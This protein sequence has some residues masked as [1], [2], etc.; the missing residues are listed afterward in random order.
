MEV[1]VPVH[2]Q[3]Y[4]LVDT[5]SAYTLLDIAY[6]PSTLTNTITA[7]KVTLMAANGSAVNVLGTIQLPI[8]LNGKQYT[9]SVLV[10]SQLL[11][12]MI[13]GGDF[14]RHFKSV[15]DYGLSTMT[16]ENN[17]IKLRNFKTPPILLAVTDKS[18]TISECGTVPVHM[19]SHDIPVKTTGYY[20]Y[21]PDIS[22]WAGITNV[23]PNFILHVKEGAFQVAVAVPS[24][25]LQLYLPE[26][27]IL[28]KLI[29]LHQVTAIEGQNNVPLDSADELINTLQIDQNEYL[30]DA[31]RIELKQTF[32]KYA[33][34]FASSSEQVTPTS[35]LT[36]EIH[37]KPDAPEVI[38]V[39]P[40]RLALHLVQQTE[41]E[42]QRLLDNGVIVPSLSPHNSPAVIVKRKD[43]Q[44]RIC[45]DYRN[46]NL[47]TIGY[48]CPLQ[49]V[50]EIVH[51]FGNKE[52]YCTFDVKSAYHT[53][54]LR[55]IDQPL[56]SF[57][58]GNRTFMWTRLATGL[59][60][61]PRY[62][63]KFLQQVFEGHLDEICI[64]FDDLLISDDTFEGI[65]RKIIL[66]M[67]RLKQANV[68][69]SPKKCQIYK[70]KVVYLG[71]LLSKEGFTMTA[72]RIK[73]IQDL[74]FPTTR[75]GLQRVLGVLNFVRRFVPHYSEVIKPITILLR[76]DPDIRKIE[77][78]A[79]SIESFQKLKTLLTNPPLLVIPQKDKTI[80]VMCDGSAIAIGCCIGHRESSTVFNPI[81][82]DSR[83]LS[84]RESKWASF[85]IEFL[86][87][88]YF[89]RK[90]HYLL[91]G[92]KF[93]VE[94]DLALLTAK[95]FLTKGDCTL[96]LRWS[97]YLSTFDFQLSHVPGA[98]NQI[99][100]YLSRLT[101]EDLYSYWAK[102]AKEQSPETLSTAVMT[103][104]N[105]KMN[106]SNR[107]DHS[108]S[109]QGTF[110]Q[111]LPAVCYI[112]ARSL[113]KSQED[114]PDLK[115]VRAWSQENQPTRREAA[116][117]HV[118]LKSLWNKRDS[119]VLNGQG[120][121]CYKKFLKKS[122]KYQLVPLIPK[123]LQGEAIRLVHRSALSPHPGEE[124]TYDV[125]RSS[126]YW[127]KMK[128]DV[129]DFV[130]N[131]EECFIFNLRFKR[132]GR[133][134]MQIFPPAGFPLQT[135]HY[136]IVGPI[137]DNKKHKSYILVF[138][139]RYSKFLY[140]EVLERQTE[141]DVLRVLN[142]FS[143]TY[144][145]PFSLV[146]DNANNLTGSELL[147]TYFAL[148]N[149]KKVTISS[150]RPNVNGLCERYNGVIVKCLRKI[151]A[152]RVQDWKK[153]LPHIIYGLNSMKNETT[154]YTP[155]FLFL[156]R[157][158]RTPYQVVNQ[159]S[160]EEE[161]TPA[162][163]SLSL[164]LKMQEAFQTVQQVAH[165]RMV[166]NKRM[167]DGHGTNVV[168]YELRDIVFVH[169][170]QLRVDDKPYSKFRSYFRGPYLVIAKH[171]EYNLLLADLKSEKVTKAHHDRVRKVTQ[172]LKLTLQIRYSAEIKE[173]LR[174][175]GLSPHPPEVSSADS[176]PKEQPSQIDDSHPTT[177]SR[178]DEDQEDE[179]VYEQQIGL[180]VLHQMIRHNGYESQAG[181][182]VNEDHVV[183]S[184]PRNNRPSGVQT[185]NSNQNQGH[186]AV[187]IGLPGATENRPS[188]TITADTEVIDAQPRSQSPPANLRRSSRRRNKP[189]WHRAYDFRN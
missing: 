80:T 12:I 59:K 58:V 42:V 19:V 112:D 119:I 27:T 36:S 28:G 105:E 150:Y 113:I 135:V 66:I 88:Y 172:Q 148:I 122:Q 53:I 115:I 81:L 14:L 163:R 70:K 128:K 153:M 78:S 83:T 187:Q 39:K 162:Q 77:P 125:I 108:T 127:P 73:I 84:E 56:T 188:V 37:L 20:L 152:N 24:S 171:S 46:L 121:C 160:L 61:A 181:T 91:H 133:Y 136:D 43:N 138:V 117:Y 149:L 184:V 161:L 99:A 21:I 47:H 29:P 74:K 31:Q 111:P 107:E 54:P 69:L 8:T 114:D 140:A 104:T 92:T 120:I 33:E 139:D 75:K 67:D 109:Y 102:V 10:V 34:V 167:Y 157:N 186:E 103:I 144:G 30:T 175:A 141:V 45:A 4:A 174:K 129:Y 15:L 169:F 100:D 96:L 86:A 90:H 72:D 137:S 65:Q 130:R 26:K 183:P 9:W 101:S 57:S 89:V 5:G 16:L 13:I 48:T 50:D 3:V 44:V 158:F 93:R 182:A 110:D 25:E 6:I 132:K 95:N 7:S 52:F 106:A 164:E 142:R 1:V 40:R 18:T 179:E 22:L 170:P 177:S 60:N 94:T 123:S 151:I 63:V 97:I 131:C 11:H 118:S 23:S 51:S 116:P 126:G 159:I 87:I 154:G 176:R 35:L 17:V 62:Y 155:S 156:G 145:L 98:Q 38:F 134:P 71:S 168:K 178:C 189:Q 146:S 143:M 166:Q 41:Q 82:Y 64:F 32:L 55:S 85:K 185:G 76:G 68:K 180:P 79:E 173:A 124:K 49:T 147:Q 165:K 2:Q